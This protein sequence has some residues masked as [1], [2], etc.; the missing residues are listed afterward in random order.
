[1]QKRPKG[2]G[3]VIYDTELRGPYIHRLWATEDEARYGLEDLLKPYREGDNWR[4]RLGVKFY[5]G[6][7]DVIQR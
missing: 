7:L 3:W 2:S 6:Y 1:M 5:G 4:K